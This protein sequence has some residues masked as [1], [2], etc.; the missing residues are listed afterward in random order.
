MTPPKRFRHAGLDW[1]IEVIRDLKDEAGEEIFG[2]VNSDAFKVRIGNIHPQMMAV[3]TFHELTHV[4]CPE[5]PEE[6]V[7]EFEKV[8]GLL[9]DNPPLVRFL[10]L[11]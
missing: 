8:Y 9:K 2:D 4:A 10:F 5:M 11:K 1:E 3:T 6:M 7:V